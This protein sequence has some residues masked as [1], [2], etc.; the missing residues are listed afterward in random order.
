[1]KDFNLLPNDDS[2]FAKF[3]KG[4]TENASKLTYNEN[5]LSTPA[6]VNRTTGVIEVKRSL[7]ENNHKFIVDRSPFMVY[8][9]LFHIEDNIKHKVN[10][11]KKRILE[12][13]DYADKQLIRFKK[14]ENALVVNGDIVTRNKKYPADLVGFKIMLINKFWWRL[15]M[16]GIK[17]RVKY[18]LMERK[19][20]RI[21]NGK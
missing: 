17:R 6:R 10:I 4:F 13:Y 7:F 8:H 19:I 20:R 3:V 14:S 2:E 5:S 18:Y 9:E 11:T 21:I 15:G 12:W 16:F 1:V